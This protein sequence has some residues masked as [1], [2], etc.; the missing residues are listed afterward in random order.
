[1]AI[2]ADTND[3]LSDILKKI[4]ETYSPIKSEWL[5]GAKNSANIYF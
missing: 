2:R 3:T 1:M 5:M 4:G